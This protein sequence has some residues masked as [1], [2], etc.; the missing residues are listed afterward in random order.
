MAGE[1]LI[2]SRKTPDGRWYSAGLTNWNGREL[3][4]DTTFL[5]EG[6]WEAK[7]HRDGPNAN[8][9]AEDYKIETLTVCAGDK[10]P[11]KMANGGGWVAE[12]VKK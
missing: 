12:F 10:L 5:G 4:L 3:T 6:E 7:I 1:Y 2:I 8:T 11:V 9:W